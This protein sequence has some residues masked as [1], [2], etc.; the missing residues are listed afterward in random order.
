MT[1]FKNNTPG[2]DWIKSFLDRNG[3]T[4]KKGGSYDAISKEECDKYITHLL[5]IASMIPQRLSLLTKN[6]LRGQI[7]FSTWMNQALV[8]KW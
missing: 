7:V 8:A 1:P 2:R 5:S 4:L 6:W 3:L